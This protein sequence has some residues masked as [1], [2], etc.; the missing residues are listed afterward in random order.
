M[1]TPRNAIFV[2]VAACS[3]AMAACQPADGPAERVGKDIDH[4]AKKLGDQVDKAA[5]KAKDTANDAKK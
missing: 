2:F 4:A 5:D 3:L 1:L